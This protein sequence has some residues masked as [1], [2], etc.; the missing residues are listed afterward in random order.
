MLDNWKPSRLQLILFA[1]G[2]GLLYA[3][4]N[5]G[6]RWAGDVGIAFLGVLL[7]AVGVDTGLNRLALFRANGWA[8]IVDTYRGVLEFLWAAIL[9]CAGLLIVTVV[10]VNWIVPGGVGNIWSDML[11]SSTGIGAILSIIGLM[12]MLNGLIRAL[13]GSPG[14][15]FARPGTLSSLADKLVGAAGVGVGMVVAAVGFVLLVAPQLLT[16]GARLLLDLIQ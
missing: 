16:E 6:V 1:I 3:G 2:A 11:Q 10:A 5:W 9:I 7:V 13:A 12:V 4:Q 8:N 15:A 14:M